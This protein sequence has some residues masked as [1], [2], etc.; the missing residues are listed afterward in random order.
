MMRNPVKLLLVIVG[1]LFAQA[2][3]AQTT[4]QTPPQS[5]A[6]LFNAPPTPSVSFN[7]DGSMM[8]VLE[9]SDAPSIEDL[10]QPEL[11]IGGIRI[12]PATSGPSRSGSFFNVK[13]KNTRSGEEIQISRFATKSQR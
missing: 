2:I 13:I 8:M 12:N 4:Y 5:I 1:A 7:K 10:A 9:R 11:R 6:D 3:Q